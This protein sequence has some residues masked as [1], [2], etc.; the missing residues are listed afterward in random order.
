M[1]SV[2]HSHEL[3]A[4]PICSAYKGG[5]TVTLLY[6]AVLVAV[7]SLETKTFAQRCFSYC[8]PK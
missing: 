5:I 3:G 6:E 7:Q 8:A 1:V 4:E 2:A